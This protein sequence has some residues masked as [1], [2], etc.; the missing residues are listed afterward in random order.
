MVDA[1][2]KASGHLYRVSALSF[3]SKLRDVSHILAGWRLLPNRFRNDILRRSGW[4]IGSGSNVHWGV[5]PVTRKVTIGEGCAVSHHAFFDGGGSVVIEDSVRIGTFVKILTTTHPIQPRE[6]RREPGI[7]E[8]L[9]TRVG[10]GS[11]L[12]ANVTLLPGITVGRGCVIG[13]GAVVAK[14]TEPNGLYVGNPARRVRDLPVEEALTEP[15]S[16]AP[17]QT[18]GSDLPEPVTAERERVMA[19]VDLDHDHWATERLA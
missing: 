10:F 9:Q 6:K 12:G 14:D 1:G 4:S 16:A 13:A 7:D 11:W 15:P 3:R 18:A 8:N 19:H 2:N 5:L 17:A